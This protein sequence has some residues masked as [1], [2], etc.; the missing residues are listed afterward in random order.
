MSTATKETWEC[1]V[2]DF[3]E[4]RCTLKEKEQ[5]YLLD[6]LKGKSLKAESIRIHRAFSLDDCLVVIA[7]DRRSKKRLFYHPKKQLIVE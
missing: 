3:L 6:F 7:E 5:D 4:I 1:L 2:R